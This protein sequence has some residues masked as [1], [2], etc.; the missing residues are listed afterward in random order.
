MINA[1]YKF[2]PQLDV[3]KLT[4]EF[5]CCLLLVKDAVLRQES[6]TKMSCKMLLDCLV[7][8]KADTKGVLLVLKA[9]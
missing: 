9:G 2:V 8:I 4:D 1:F 7:E 5:R 3:S 6:F